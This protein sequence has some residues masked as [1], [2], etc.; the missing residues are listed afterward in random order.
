MSVNFFGQYAGFFSLQISGHRNFPPI[1]WVTQSQ[2]LHAN[3]IIYELCVSYIKNIAFL[4]QDANLRFPPP[5]YPT[6]PTRPLSI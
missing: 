6:L 4:H 5:E 2:F 3:S 1:I